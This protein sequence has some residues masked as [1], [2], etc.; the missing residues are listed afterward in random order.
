MYSGRVMDEKR[1]R[2]RERERK[3]KK[4][5]ERVRERESEC[6]FTYMLKLCRSLDRLKLKKNWRNKKNFFAHQ[7]AVQLWGPIKKNLYIDG[8]RNYQ[9]LNRGF[10]SKCPDLS[11]V[12]FGQFLK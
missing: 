12:Y 11:V 3:R 9:S 1:E 5:R 2:E 6:V 10:E 7:N 4:E 8:F